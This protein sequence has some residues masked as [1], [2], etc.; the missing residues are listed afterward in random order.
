VAVAGRPEVVADSDH[1]EAGPQEI[2]RPVIAHP[3]AVE[4]DRLVTDHPEAVEIDRPVTDHPE[5]DS[6]RP[7]TDRPVTDR[8][9]ADNG[10]REAPDRVATDRL[11]QPVIPP[12]RPQNNTRRSAT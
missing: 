8:P 6:D 9:K 2:D 7:V 11:Q 10:R 3:E 4:I 1:R 12:H 5:A